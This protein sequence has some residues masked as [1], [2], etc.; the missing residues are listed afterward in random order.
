[1]SS[2]TAVPSQSIWLPVVPV[3]KERARSGNGNHYTPAR[4]KQFQK[5]IGWALKTG[6][7]RMHET[8]WLE[9]ESTFHLKSLA[10]TRSDIDNYVKSLFDAC[11]K[12]AW[13]DDKQVTA[14][15]IYLRK[16]IND[17]KGITFS[18]RPDEGAES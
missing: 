3:G 16:A 10:T 1:M 2:A 9:V 13:T 18:V 17:E 5:D 4:T 11:N 6:G 15:H 8:G 12:I 7:V 14:M